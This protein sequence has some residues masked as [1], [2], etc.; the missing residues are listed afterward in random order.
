MPSKTPIRTV[1]FFTDTYKPAVNGVVT[2]VDLFAGEL[3]LQG[4][5][6]W[7]FGPASPRYL[8]EPDFV[9]LRSV[10]LPV[11][12]DFRLG[13][14]LSKRG[15]R[16]PDIG[17][18]VVHVH[19]PGPIGVL[20]LHYGS[21]KGVPVV[22]T[23]H[24]MLADYARHYVPRALVGTQHV[25]GWWQ[26]FL[27]NR[28][29]LVTAP[30]AF[31]KS[32]LEQIGIERPVVV[33]PTGLDLHRFG[34]ARSDARRRFGVPEGRPVVVTASR[35]AREKNIGLIVDAFAVLKAIRPDACLLVVGGGPHRRRL[36]QQA[37]E[38][39]VAGDVVFTGMVSRDD[40]AALLGVSDLFVY[41]CQTDT[42]GLVVMEAMAAGLP[43]VVVRERVFE[44]FVQDGVNGYLLAPDAFLFARRMDSLLG[45]RDLRQLMAHESRRLAQGFSIE[46]QAAELARLYDGL[47]ADKAAKLVRTE[48][49]R[50]P[51]TAP[52]ASP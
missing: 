51:A 49:R 39:K 30:T 17:A 47:L 36:E 33:L 4:T 52:P 5:R 31:V 8:P 13:W 16:V 44:P 46:R 20:G 15:L 37:Q 34:S 1:A 43:L 38:L 2:A 9:G 50:R 42:Q 6:V 24:A 40:V 22:Q 35:V 21:S 7:I 14:P 18:D 25:V 11:A 26:H 28:A 45:S 12:P 3:R 27:Y 19:S 29:D 23:Y 48:G 41:A 32:Y 10:P